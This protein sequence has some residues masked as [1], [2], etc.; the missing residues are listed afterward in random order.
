MNI[1]PIDMTSVPLM[2]NSGS[3]PAPPLRTLLFRLFCLKGWLERQSS[4]QNVIAASLP[5]S[6]QK[7]DK[8]RQKIV[9]NGRRCLQLKL[10]QIA[11]RSLPFVNSHFFIVE[12]FPT[13]ISMLSV[14]DLKAWRAQLLMSSKDKKANPS[15][16]YDIYCQIN[17]HKYSERYFCR[18]S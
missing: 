18:S 9:E 11:T 4:L 15:Y 17:T 6:K 13:F 7:R 2:T 3:V 16:I 12:L 8:F 1:L 10:G 5:G 14:C